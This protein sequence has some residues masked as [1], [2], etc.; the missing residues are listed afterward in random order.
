M[1]MTNMSVAFVH[2]CLYCTSCTAFWAF[3]W[4]AVLGSAGACV[5]IRHVG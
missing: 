1:K 2:L 5:R 4:I 3:Q